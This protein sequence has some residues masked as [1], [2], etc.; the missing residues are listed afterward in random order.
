MRGAAFFDT[1]LGRRR[2]PPPPRRIRRSLRGRRFVHVSPVRV[3]KSLGR[4]VG[5]GAETKKRSKRSK[6]T[7]TSKR[8]HEIQVPCAK[9]TKISKNS[10]ILVS[11]A[12]FHPQP[13]VLLIQI[14][15]NT[16][17]SPAPRGLAHL[18]GW[19]G[20]GDGGGGGWVHGWFGVRS[21]PGG[22]PSLV[23]C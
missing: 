9:L 4:G 19:V 7:E 12:G 20:G 22:T 3:S 14:G 21:A 1:G 6:R 11:A 17:T 5:P 2:P 15:G 13:S 10:G 16:N 8:H 18:Q 23:I